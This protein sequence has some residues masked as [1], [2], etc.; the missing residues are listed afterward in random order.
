MCSG[1]ED[2]DF[3]QTFLDRYKTEFGF[4]L[5]NREVLIDD[6]RVRGTGS[7][8]IDLGPELPPSKQ[9][10]LVEKVTKVYFEGGYQETSIYLMEN[11][12]PGH[13]IHGPSIIMDQ[14]ST[15]LVEPQCIASVTSRG[16]IKIDVS[17]GDKKRVG[18]DLDTIQ[19][20]I[21]SH[22]FQSCNKYS[23]KILGECH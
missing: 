13:V 9:P 11:L 14:L 23:L 6:I 12:A 19:L 21:F 5:Q 17:G 20:S 2:V 15:I 22:R 3:M 1:T 16:D 8:G 7:S 4:V 18:T 10:P